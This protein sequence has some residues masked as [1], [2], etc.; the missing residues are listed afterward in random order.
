[1]KFLIEQNADY[2]QSKGKTLLIQYE[3]PI[4]SDQTN[5]DL[6]FQQKLQ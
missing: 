4:K 6:R 3:L 1:M 5:I 2:F